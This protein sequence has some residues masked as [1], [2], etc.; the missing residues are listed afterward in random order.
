MGKNA[1]RILQ[2][3]LSEDPSKLEHE[4]DQTK[5]L[6]NKKSELRKSCKWEERPIEE[7]GE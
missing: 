1:K 6:N 3:V 7:A 5:N 2:G 4:T